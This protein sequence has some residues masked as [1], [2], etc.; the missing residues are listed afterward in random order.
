M[1]TNNIKIK[2]KKIISILEKQYPNAKTELTYDAKFPYQLVVAVM[3]SAQA[4]DVGVNK[5]TPAMFKKYKTPF[6]FSKATFND[7]IQYTKSINFYKAKTQ[8]IIDNATALVN[9]Y[10]G[11]LPKSIDKLIKLPGIGRKSANVI[12]Q[13]LFNIN[14]GI[15]VDTHMLRVSKRLG[16]QNCSKPKDA[17]KVEQ[18]LL[19]VIPKNKYSSFSRR[20]V[21]L[22]RYI[23]KAKKPNCA[24]C[25]L[26]KI[27]D[28]AFKLS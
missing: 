22:G 20:M 27:C 13:E 26:N 8:R 4:T 10:G 19:L 14:E 7:L 18:D 25:P 3:L 12:L 28:S 9:N 2:A 15:V 21:L 5:A 1:G 23:C 16:L 11:E 6:D 17:V 24:D